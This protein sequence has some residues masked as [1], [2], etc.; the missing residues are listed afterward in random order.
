MFNCLLIPVF[1]FKLDLW[2]WEHLKLVSEWVL[3]SKLRF[4]TDI[5]VGPHNKWAQ[6]VYKLRWAVELRNCFF[7]SNKELRWIYA[8]WNLVS[9]W[10]LLLKFKFEIDEDLLDSFAWDWIITSRL[11][12]FL[13]LESSTIAEMSIFLISFYGWYIPVPLR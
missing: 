3:I 12:K 7:F 13:V 2:Y 1:R 10:I 6:F 4:D 8:E 9:K 5:S 11:C